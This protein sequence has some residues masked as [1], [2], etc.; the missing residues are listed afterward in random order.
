MRD[1]S[2]CTS[3]NILPSVLSRASPKIGVD[4]NVNYSSKSKVVHA[5]SIHDLSFVSSVTV[6]TEHSYSVQGGRTVTVSH[7]DY[8]YL[9]SVDT[10]DAD[11]CREGC[12]SSIV[13]QLHADC[14]DVL[15]NNVSR[16]VVNFD[17][18][19]EVYVLEH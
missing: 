10:G 9:N 16:Q 12:L 4:S 11:E 17:I 8:S 3:S 18:N 14:S 1:K 15:W 19:Y 13:D 6:Q 7:E 2:S 5:G